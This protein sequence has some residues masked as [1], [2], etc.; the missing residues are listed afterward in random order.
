MLIAMAGLPGAGKSSVA[1]GLGRALRAPVVSVDP[2]EAALR[3][4]GVA[5]GRLTGLAAYLAAEAV[6]DG[7]LALGQSVIVDAVNAVEPAR[8]RWRALAARHGVALRVIEVCC[9]SPTVHRARLEARHRGIAGLPE[10]T[11]ADVEARRAEFEPWHEER[12]SLDSTADLAAN[13][14]RALGYAAS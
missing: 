9:S 13:I 11:W 12:L 14:E 6:A 3:R 1:E 4:A 2:I 5:P 10:P 7:V 8:G